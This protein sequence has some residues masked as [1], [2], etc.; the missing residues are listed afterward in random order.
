L[1]SVW[2]KNLKDKIEKGLIREFIDKN[3][4]TKYVPIPTAQDIE[5]NRK[6]NIGKKSSEES[7]TRAILPPVVVTLNV[8]G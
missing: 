1:T 7:L 8:V 5:R 2:L 3:G 6:A 4:K